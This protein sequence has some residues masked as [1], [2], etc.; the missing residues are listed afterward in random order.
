MFI[1]QLNY[2]KNLNKSALKNR[3]IRT[4]RHS[5]AVYFCKIITCLWNIKAQTKDKLTWPLGKYNIPRN[6]PLKTCLFL[7]LCMPLLHLKV[8]AD[9]LSVIKKKK[10]GLFH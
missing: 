2:K 9:E 5:R 7:V 3:I 8:I 4:L 10:L 6:S 1:F